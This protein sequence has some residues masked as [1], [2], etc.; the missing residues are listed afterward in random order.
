MLCHAKLAP[1][2]G[3]KKH[4]EK[5]NYGMKKF[6]KPCPIDIHV[7]PSKSVTS[8][9]TGEK[10]IINGE[11]NCFTK[12]VVYLTTCAKCQKQ[13]I[14][15]TGRSFHDRIREHM[16]DI[17]RGIRTSG[18]HYKQEGHTHWDFQVQIIEKVTPNSE[19]LRLE[20]EEFWIRKFATKIPFGMNV[21]D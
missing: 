10:H 20:R 3:P 21:L 4:P 2:E 12:G 9:V 14:G 17:K 5:N 13:Y 6:N 8:S 19:L 1:K 7:L 15:Q 18:I 16:Y 11:F